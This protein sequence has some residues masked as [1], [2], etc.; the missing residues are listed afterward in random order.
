MRYFSQHYYIYMVYM[1]VQREA[2]LALACPSECSLCP[3]QGA[4]V[5]IPHGTYKACRS[6]SRAK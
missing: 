2:V 1:A 3:L 4:I 6:R 5:N